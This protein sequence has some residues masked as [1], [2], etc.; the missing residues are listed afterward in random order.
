L[1]ITVVIFALQTTTD[2]KITRIKIRRTYWPK[3]SPDDFVLEDIGQ[4]SLDI[5]A[6][7]AVAES[8]RTLERIGLE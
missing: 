3:T 6:V 7:W 1:G 8:C 4:A 5:G 2:K